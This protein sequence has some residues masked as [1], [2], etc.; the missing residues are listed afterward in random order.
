DFLDG[1]GKQAVLNG[2]LLFLDFSKLLLELLFQNGE[3]LKGSRRIIGRNSR[4]A[5]PS[6]RMARRIVGIRRWSRVR[7][8]DVPSWRMAKRIVGIRRSR[9][10]IFD[11]PSWRIARR[12]VG[13]RRSRVRI[14]DEPSWRMA[15][16]VVAQR[17]YA[18]H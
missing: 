18:N 3:S 5:K 9:V 12:I 6:W 13:I 2:G 17:E 15:R 10:R 8:F 11:P 1:F 14:N 16:R 7:I 4:Q